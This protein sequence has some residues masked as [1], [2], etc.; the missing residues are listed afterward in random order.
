MPSATIILPDNL[1]P[2][3]RQAIAQAVLTCVPVE[4]VNAT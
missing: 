4:K 2:L 3:E 1:G